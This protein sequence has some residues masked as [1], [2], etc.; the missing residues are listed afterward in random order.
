MII[1]DERGNNE[2]Y[3]GHDLMGVLVQPQR[4][5]NRICRFLEMYHDIRDGD[6]HDVLQ[7]DIMEEWWKWHGVQRN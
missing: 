6:M 3:G 7:K 1:E 2:V 5:R 4:D